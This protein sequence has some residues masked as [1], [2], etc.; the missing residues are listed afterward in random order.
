MT[1]SLVIDHGVT[2]SRYLRCPSR[3]DE[4]RSPGGLAPRHLRW[5]FRGS[6]RDGVV[7]DSF[8]FRCAAGCTEGG[9][10][11]L[12]GRIVFVV[13]GLDRAHRFAPHLTQV[14]VL[15]SACVNDPAC[16]RSL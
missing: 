13:N 15:C 5:L 10:E 12:L 1:A 7:L 3:L 8:R 11:E 6:Y 14:G 2:K 9:E 4:F 16:E